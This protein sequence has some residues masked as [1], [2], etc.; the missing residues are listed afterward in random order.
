M[1]SSS[2]TYDC[3]SENE[4]VLAAYKEIIYKNISVSKTITS[5]TSF[6]SKNKQK[7]EAAVKLWLR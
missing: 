2:P 3:A 7:Y 6:N 4:A 5:N 1:L